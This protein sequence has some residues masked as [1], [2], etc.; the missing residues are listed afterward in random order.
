[1]TKREAEGAVFVDL[2]KRMQAEREM[3]RAAEELAEDAAIA[4]VT[5][6]TP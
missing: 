6:S 1:M 2:P 5:G 4:K 3:R